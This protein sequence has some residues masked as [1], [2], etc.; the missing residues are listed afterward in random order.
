MT[1]APTRLQD[2]LKAEGILIDA[3]RAGDLRPDR[4]WRAAIGG[5]QQRIEREMEAEHGKR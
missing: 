5:I 4:T 2:L 1:A 3:V